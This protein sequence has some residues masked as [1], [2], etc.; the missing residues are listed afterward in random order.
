LAREIITAGD[1]IRADPELSKLF[2]AA[3]GHLLG[4]GENLVQ[5]ELGSIISQLRTRGAGEF[6]VGGVSQRLVA[7]AETA[8]IP[9]SQQ[10]LHSALPKVSDPL[11]FD[12]GSSKIASFTPPPADG[13]LVTAE[14]VGLLT[15]TKSWS[16]ASAAERAHMFVEASMRVLADRSHWLQGNG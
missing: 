14:L 10:T 13:G 6:Y 1:K 7:F 16:D 3:D 9:L 8:G 15:D 5:P 2:V 11:T 4:E 12:L